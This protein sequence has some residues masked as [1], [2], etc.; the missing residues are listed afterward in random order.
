MGIKGSGRTEPREIDRF[1]GGVGWIAYPEEG[2]QRAS[3][4]LATDA[5]VL[6]VDPVDAEGVEDLYAD[7]GDVAGVVLLLDRHVR[8]AATFADRHDVPVYAPAWMSGVADDLGTTPEP[9]GDLLADTDYVIERVVDNG[10]WQEAALFDAA[11]GTLVVPE[12]VGTADFFTA[13]DE[14]LGVHPVL[15]LFPPKRLRS[16]DAERV[17][18]GHGAGVLDDGAAAL[19]DAL[20]NSRTRAPAA[21]LGALKGMLG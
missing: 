10:F 15:R 1:D 5:G 17:L 2:M 4:A 12:A 14:R 7:L 11:T 9:L 6:L 19:R 13:G 21:Y 3:H 8:D 18:V 20:D 16:L